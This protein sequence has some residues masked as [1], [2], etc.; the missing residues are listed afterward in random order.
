MVRAPL[1]AAS[2]D[3]GHR[4]GAVFGVNSGGHFTLQFTVGF[5]LVNLSCGLSNG[6]ADWTPED[7]R[8]RLEPLAAAIAARMA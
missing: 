6:N 3:L 5:H 4:D 8:S 7:M 2:S 1:P